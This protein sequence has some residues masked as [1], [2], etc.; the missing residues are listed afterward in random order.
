[1]GLAARSELETA[2]ARARPREDMLRAP[3]RL[4]GSRGG[5][6]CGCAIGPSATRCTSARCCSGPTPPRP[7]AWSRRA[8]AGDPSSAPLRGEQE[9]RSPRR[10]SRSDSRVA[11]H[12]ARDGAGRSAPSQTTSET[13]AP[14]AQEVHDALRAAATDASGRVSV[15]PGPR[16]H[17]I[18]TM[19]STSARHAA[20]RRSGPGVG[21]EV[22]RERRRARPQPASRS[23]S[24]RGDRRRAEGSRRR[25]CRTK[26]S[27]ASR[28]R[29]ASATVARAPP[30]RN[31]IGAVLQPLPR[32]LRRYA[33]GA[34]SHVRG[35]RRGT[36]TDAFGIATARAQRRAD[37]ASSSAARETL[38]RDARA[39]RRWRR[40]SV[41]PT[42]QRFLCAAPRG[43]R[44]I[45]RNLAR[46]TDCRRAGRRLG[47][48]IACRHPSRR[49]SPSPRVQRPSSHPARRSVARAHGRPTTWDL[50]AV[51]DLGARNAWARREEREHAL[52]E[53]EVVHGASALLGAV[54]GPSA[55]ALSNRRA[56]GERARS[57]TD[58]QL[59]EGV[60]ELRSAPSSPAWS[61]STGTGEDRGWS[62]CPRLSPSAGREGREVVAGVRCCRPAA[63]QRNRARSTAAVMCAAIASWCSATAGSSSDARRWGFF[64]S[65]KKPASYART[66]Q[67]AGVRC[68]GWGSPVARSICQQWPGEDRQE[69]RAL[70]SKVRHDPPQG[71]GDRR[72][73]RGAP[74]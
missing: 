69:H 32:S 14:P 21:L 58:A 44:T 8:R 3:R 72:R 51:D 15:A 22:A 59:S 12:Q 24:P 65:I 52:R 67:P 2:T 40:R 36:A 10:A 43:L 61:T 25:P 23:C 9:R 7:A 66:P 71:S 18:A 31:A 17:A 70:A 41:S 38:P 19:G 54:D 63:T 74:W 39:R 37:D 48:R 20:E 6:R 45:S 11:A 28:W 34:C 60:A 16:R 62:A 5:Q 56:L 68:L 27:R 46:V 30:R 73:C 57:S 64:A 42:H 53:R 33:A 26:G 1:M 29:T 13:S 4:A 55:S 35:A 49:R 50:L 47:V